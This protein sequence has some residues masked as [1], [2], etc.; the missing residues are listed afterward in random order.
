M[1]R[2]VLGS[3]GLLWLRLVAGFG[4]ATHGYQLLFGGHM[5]EFA[6]GVRAMHFPAP[7]FFAWA[8]ALSEFLGGIL[9]ALGLKTR[10]AGAFALVT[11]AVAVFIR[12]AGDPFHVKELALLYLGAFGA[13]ILLGS[14]K[15]AL[16]RA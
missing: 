7:L 8:A 3:L 11:L 10:I 5:A 9:V 15:F 1:S 16:D 6:L 14:G 13:L 12:H 4:L 2:D